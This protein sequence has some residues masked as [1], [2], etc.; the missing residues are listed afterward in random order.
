VRVI[1]LPTARWTF[2]DELREKVKYPAS[3]PK[4]IQERAWSSPI[5]YTPKK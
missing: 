4:S 5:W 1:E 2:Y 3:V